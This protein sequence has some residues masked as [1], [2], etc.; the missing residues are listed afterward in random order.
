[1]R[2][3]QNFPPFCAESYKLLLCGIAKAFFH[4]VLNRWNFR[5]QNLNAKSAIVWLQSLCIWGIYRCHCLEALKFIWIS[6]N[7]RFDTEREAWL[8]ETHTKECVKTIMVYRRNM[9]FEIYKGFHFFYW[10][11]FTLL[12]EYNLNLKKEII[13]KG[14]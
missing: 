8:E 10:V 1:M 3:S 12:A 4:F 11:L 7:Y 2:D 9:K 14:V 6:Y 13:K 5:R